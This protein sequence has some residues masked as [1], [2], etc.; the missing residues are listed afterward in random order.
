MPRSFFLFSALLV[1]SSSASAQ[2]N[3]WVSLFDGATMAGWERV[4]NEKSVW[5][6][7]DGSLSGSGPPSML[8]NT[9]GP[10]KN[11]R[12]R[13]EIKISDGGNSGL[14]FRTTRKPGFLDGYEAQIDSTHTDPIRT[15]SLYGMCNVYKKLVEPDT[16]FEYEIE[17]RDDKWRGRE[18]TRIKII[19]NGDELYEFMDFEKTFKEGHFA[20]QHH[21][22]ESIVHIR[23]VEVMKLP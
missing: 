5:K 8:V 6:V 17:V 23:K 16:W 9:S 19:V 3:Q 13:A 7:I 12:Y 20:F 2:N 1:F 18:L 15:G 10:Y 21:D 11:F 14:Y 22:P 4:G